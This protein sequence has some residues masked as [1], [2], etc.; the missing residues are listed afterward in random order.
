MGCVAIAETNHWMRG[1]TY[2]W[3][4]AGNG[5]V[6]IGWTNTEANMPAWG[7]RDRRLGNNPL[8]FAVPYKKEAI[9]LDFA[10]TQFSYGKMEAAQ[11]EGKRMPFPG[12]F[13]L[14]GELTDD[15]AAILESW[16]ALPIG[17][18]KGAGLA[19]L[20]DILATILSAGIS[21]QQ[22]SKREAEYGVSQVF[23]AIDIKKLSNF[24]A[25]ETAISGIIA[26]L[27][28]SVPDGPDAAVR[29]PGEQIL[30][31]RTDN[32]KNGIPVNKNVWDEIILF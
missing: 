6:F 4:A 8:V 2:G 11:L 14:E 13:N 18:W 27:K 25:I 1:G 21:T 17:Y 29:Y 16:R 32:L 9:V 22:I 3:Q 19:L 10:M 24:P 5:F 20:L 12:G 28:E 26:D 31:T 15:P 23:I 7:A 30:L